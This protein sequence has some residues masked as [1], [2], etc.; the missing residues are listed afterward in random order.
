MSA[1]NAYINGKAY[2]LAAGETIYTFVSRHLGAGAIPVLCNDDALEPFGNCRLCSVDVAMSAVAPRRVKAACHTR[3]EAE[4]YIYTDTPRIEK[5]RRSIMELLLSDYPATALQP[6]PGEK[7]TAFQTLVQQLGISSSR[8]PTDRKAAS[9]DKTHPYIHFDTNECIYCYRCIRA[10][11]EIQG[12]LVLSMLGRGHDSRVIVSLDQSFKESECVAC[13]ACV[14]TCPTNALS[15]RYRTKT[16][17]EDRRVRTVC[18]Y[19]GVG[20]NLEVLLKDG[21]VRAID[22]ADDAEVNQGH[23]CVKGRYAFAYYNHPDRLRSPLLRKNGELQAVSWDEALDHIA[24]RLDGIRQTH[25][26]Q[27]IAGISSSR[28]TN[29]ENFLMQKFMR[30]VI[31]N[32]NIDGCARVCHAPTAFGMQQSFGTGAATNSIAEIPLA[33]CLLVIGANSTEAHPVTGAK[34]QQRAMKGVPLIVIDPRRIELTRYATV[35]LQLR[36][37]TNVALLDMLIYYVIKEGLVDEEFVGQRTEG[38]ADFRESALAIDMDKLE[39]VTGVARDKVREAALLYGRAHNAMSFH[40]LGLTEHYQGSRGVMLVAALAMMT[41]NIGRPGVGVNPL[42][43]QN[44]VQG[45]ADM[46]VQPNQGAGYLDVTDPAVRA[47]YEREYGHP[48]P[49]EKGLT[50]PG[51]LNAA[52]NG[53]LKALWIMGEDILQTDPDYCH[54]RHAL[55]EVEFL[56]VQELFMTETASLADV[57]LPA[58]SHLEKSGTFTNGERRVQRVNQVIP[59]LEGTR[60]DGQIM[61]DIMNRMGY[62]Q[63]GYDP[64]L[65]LTEIA[66]VV[67]FFAGIRWDNLGENGKQWPVSK[68]GQDTQILHRETFKRGKGKFTFTDFVETP[69]LLEGDADEY[70]FIL[71]TGRRLEHYNCGSMTRRT[72]NIDL[73]DRDELLI[74]PLDAA[75][76]G[77][78]DEQEIGLRSKQGRTRLR[79]RLSD[80]VRPGVLFT[81]FHFPEIAINHLTSGVLDLDADTPEFKVVAVAIEK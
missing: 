70:P 15:D 36:P 31:G 38:F 47:H 26:V 3:V 2:P 29:E 49:A 5:L 72:P 64:A 54:V 1:P 46:G 56:V 80:E 59:P 77:I 63:A 68:D 22:T 20:C 41:G 35:H 19:C 50:T 65:H 18:T 52:S 28:C 12:Q 40:G 16:F 67:P 24:A 27:A 25:G 11:D 44:N 58:A 32:N 23:A 53:D 7:P 17:M 48:V 61:V 37:G 45:A 55:S 79:A 10:C 71:T 57:V 60:P 43:G 81:T 9:V 30:V 76:Y 34:M 73:L 62:A 66:R 21:E 8:F 78:I 74:N 14:Q 13:G 51:M 6:L 75:A 4:Q 42:R 33:D 39:Q 69:Q